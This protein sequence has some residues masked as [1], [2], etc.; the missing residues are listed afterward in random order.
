MKKTIPVRGRAPAT[1]TLALIAPL[2]L[3]V[4]AAGCGRKAPKADVTAVAEVT[5]ASASASA[6]AS[7]TGSTSAKAEPPLLAFEPLVASP[8]PNRLFPVEGAIVVATQKQIGRLVDG[9]V[10]WRAEALE[11]YDEVTEV[12]GRWPD[13]LDLLYRSRAGRTPELFYR[14]L[15]GPGAARAEPGRFAKGL[16][17]IGE[18]TLLIEWSPTT[19]EELVTVRGKWRERTRFKQPVSDQGL[20]SCSVEERAQANISAYGYGVLTHAIGGLPSGTLLTLVMVC[21]SRGSSP[22]RAARS[23]ATTRG[24]SPRCRGSA[25]RPS[26][27]AARAGR[28][29]RPTA[30]PCRRSATARGR[31][32]G[33]S[34]GRCRA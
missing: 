27:S 29:T 30:A 1:V 3:L 11:S 18:S 10:E 5:A 32:S 12:Q 14:P 33:A 25:T 15:T 26:P 31:R 19:E 7:T 6:S 34:P 21:R 8:P 20:P 9:K 17:T 24:R 28:C 22:A 23:S 2:S 13:R 16:A 4:M